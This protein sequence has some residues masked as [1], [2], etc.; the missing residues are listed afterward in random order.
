HIKQ[1]FLGFDFS[2]PLWISS[3]TGGTEKAK[4]INKNLAKA[5]AE[6][7]I[8]MGLGS[9]RPLLES[10]DRFDDFNVKSLMGSAPLFANLGIAQLEELIENSDL[11]K[12]TELIKKLD[13]DGLV[14]HVNPLQEW[15]QPE[16]D[17][18]K[19]SAIE[20]IQTICDFISLPIIVKEVGQGMGPKS[21]EALL[22]TSVS[23]IELAGY[24]GTNFSLLEM[25]RSQG[26]TPD[27]ESSGDAFSY[28]GHT[29]EQMIDYLNDLNSQK[30]TDI[31]VIIS[32][33]VKDPVTGHILKEKLELNSIVGMASN[34]LKYALKDYSEL[35]AYLIDVRESFSMAKCFLIKEDAS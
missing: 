30:T 33:G 5:C 28:V 25:R 11:K 23:A 26:N 7:K 29:S 17:R 34:V 4:H 10:D 18:Y 16:G 15:A 8:G 20:T 2:M 14:I 13:A 21:L 19:K 1:K 9:C 31:E 12:L 35:Q 24:G 6:F 32:G 27:I 3:M 22:D